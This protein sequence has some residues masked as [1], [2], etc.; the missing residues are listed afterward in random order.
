MSFECSSSKKGSVHLA[1]AVQTCF[2][3]FIS[4]FVCAPVFGGNLL[5]E[6]DISLFEERI[7]NNRK[8]PVRISIVDGQ[9]RS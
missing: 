6:V 1:I 9:G 5:S 7:E 8:I 4:L 3:L 2:L